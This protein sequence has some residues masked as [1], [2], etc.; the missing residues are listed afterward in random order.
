MAE[1]FKA[2]VWKAGVRLRAYR[3]FESHSLRQN[4]I[5]IKKCGVNRAII[6]L[7]ITFYNKMERWHEWFKASVSKTDVRQ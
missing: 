6:N 4:N 5:L 1:W 7:W 3:G 2:P